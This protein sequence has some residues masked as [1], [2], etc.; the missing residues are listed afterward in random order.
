MKKVKFLLVLVMTMVFS[1]AMAQKTVV[2][3]VL[4]DKN[5][6]EG[7]PFATVRIFKQGETTRPVSMFLTD[8]DGNFSRE[9]NG[10][11]KFN[12]IFSSVG[13]EDLSKS[14]ELSGNG[15]LNL[16]TIYI[17]ENV[18]ELSDVAIVA[19]KPLVK[20]EVDK[21]SYS[22]AEDEDAKSSTVLDMLRKVPMVTVD[23]QDNISVNGSSSFKVYVDGKPNV[24]FSSN[25]SLIFKSMPA[26][27]V[28]NIEVVTNPGARYDAEGASGVL[29]IV[30]NRMDT[31]A[32]ESMNGY[33]G[34]I[35]VSAGNRS[36][37]GGAFVSGQQ[38]KFSYSG[39]LMENYSTPG[40]TDVE[41]EQKNGD[42]SILT[43]AATKVK[44]PFTM[45][46]VSLGYELDDM[47]SV[48]ATFSLTSFNMK[49]DG[50]TTTSQTGGLYGNGFNYVNDMKMHNK[51][52]SF[53]GNVDYQRFFN[54]ERTKSFVLTYQ[55]DYSPSKMEQN[56]R[57]SNTEMAVIDLTNRNSVNKEHTTDHTIQADFTTPLG[58]NNK[59]SLGSKLMMR[60]ADS[61]AKYYLADVYDERSSMDYLYK[62]TIL[63]GYS[64][65]TGQWDKLGAKAGLRYE[66]TWQNVEYRLGQGQNFST[67]YGSLVPSASL[68]YTL[69]PTSN[70]GLTY[71]MRISRPG[72]SYLNPYVNRADPNSLSYGNTDL[73]VEKSHNISLVYNLYSTKLM[74]NVNVHHNFT[75][76]AIE[77]YSF[78]DGTLLNTTYGNIVK[79]HQTG[80]NV[81]ANWLL[82]PKTRIMLN[83]GLNYNDM[84]SSVLDL[85]NS[86]WQGNMMAGLQQTMPWDLKLG[87]YLITSTKSYTLQGWS[88]GFNI[89]TANLSKSFFND[90]LSVSI[91]GML[92]LSD[93]GNLKMETYSQGKNFLSHQTIKVPMSGF[94]VSVSYT[95]GNTKQ[96]AKQHVS[97]VQ[98]DY[99]EQQSQ[100]EMLNNVGNVGQ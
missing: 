73:D 24:M 63:A 15:T 9:V 65:Y 64:E 94:N 61:D 7:E 27:A 80:V 69:A 84:R 66:Q 90:K 5:L 11:G 52:T 22:V 91:Q 74:L 92:G 93:G 49:N 25:P 36:I 21:M 8:K 85:K 30:M 77:Q 13:K 96:K 2:K 67:N 76:N 18:N 43:S 95:F 87:A 39:N 56:N 58:Q 51:K 28:K 81:Y 72:I 48:N 59:L 79:R 50:H 70:I 10:K 23:G 26:S 44:I 99:I 3:G 71:N 86:G 42:G 16:D 47:S 40:T 60:R 68:S 4:I 33:N 12:I 82:A 31:K 98:N 1:V 32:M 100:G 55:L 37:G 41:M 20:M 29:N 62:N 38:G 54:K 6:G 14:I 75:D 97:R 19:Q 89:L 35:R 83:G 34:T 45:G 46:N 57:F 53:S 78:F 17:K 88:S